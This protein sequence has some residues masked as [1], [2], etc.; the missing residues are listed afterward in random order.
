MKCA[1]ITPVFEKGCRN[2]KENYRPVSILPVIS[3]IFVKLMSKQL[4]TFF[5]SI[6]SKCQ[7]GFRKG[8]ITQHCLLL[9]LDKWKKAVNNQ[10]AFGALPTD[11]SKAFDYLN[12][13]LFIAKS[14]SYGI[15]FF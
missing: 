4:S 14:H 13:H 11:L 9:M 1:N 12:H 6:L 8:F 5:E 3:K 7:W 2:L 15:S 10:Q